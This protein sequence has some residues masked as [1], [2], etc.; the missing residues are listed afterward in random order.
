MKRSDYGIS[1]DDKSHRILNHTM[2][3]DGW[4]AN[5]FDGGSIRNLRAQ[6][7]NGAPFTISR[8]PQHEWYTG[9]LLSEL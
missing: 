2:N 9:R 5:Y 6:V 1:P 4:N 3:G 7:L 8:N